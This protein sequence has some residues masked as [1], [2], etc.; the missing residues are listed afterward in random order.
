M[1]I[2]IMIIPKCQYWKGPKKI[3]HEKLLVLLL[4]TRMTYFETSNARKMNLKL[5]ETNG[6]NFLCFCNG[7][8]MYTQVYNCPT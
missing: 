2:N 1:W 6:E 4:L 5:K 8:I 3:Q 7:S